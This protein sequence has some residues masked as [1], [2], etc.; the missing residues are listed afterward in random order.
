VP[1]EH[2]RGR[3]VDLGPVAHVAHLPLAAD[4]LGEQLQTL[5][6]PGEEDAEPSFLRELTRG[7]LADPRRGAGDHRY[8]LA[9]HRRATLSD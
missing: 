8:P 1:R 6:A 9:G 3:F 7:R 2:T 5:R 4:L